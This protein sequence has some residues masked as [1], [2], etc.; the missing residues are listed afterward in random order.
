MNWTNL[1]TVGKNIL[2][3]IEKHW[4]LVLLILSALVILGVVNEI[5]SCSINSHLNADIKSLQSNN[6][7]LRT[8]NLD[9]SADARILAGQL[10]QGNDLAAK[11]QSDNRKLEASLGRSQADNAE[12]EKRINNSQGFT[13]IISSNN[14]TATGIIEN[15]AE[16]IGRAISEGTGSRKANK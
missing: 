13:D 2:G 11:L 6:D 8:N 15:V 12:L 1:L 10:K 16:S 7:K 3:F 9:I 14:T 5:F 4:K